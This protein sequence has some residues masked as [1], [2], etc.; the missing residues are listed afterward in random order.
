MTSQETQEQ[1]N[2]QVLD[3]FLELYRQL[4]PWDRFQVDLYLKWMAFQRRLGKIVWDWLIFQWKI[5]K[6]VLRIMK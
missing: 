6:T 1:E 5:N 2:R 4:S 3:E